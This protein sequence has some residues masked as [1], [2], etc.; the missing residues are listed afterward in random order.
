VPRP[1]TP[2]RPSQKRL[3]EEG[4]SSYWG[5]DSNE[6]AGD[7][8]ANGT[9]QNEEAAASSPVDGRELCE[10]VADKE[11][12]PLEQKRVRTQEETAILERM[13]F[14]DEDEELD[15][16][17]W[18]TDEALQT[19]VTD[20]GEHEGASAPEQQDGG[21]GDTTETGVGRECGREADGASKSDGLFGST[22]TTWPSTASEDGH[23][24]S[25]QGEEDGNA[26]VVQGV[27]G[28]VAGV[29]HPST[30]R[31]A[32]NRQKTHRPQ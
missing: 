21:R 11:K 18:E 31:M 23:P 8:I 26:A 10:A 7:T 29:Q 19:A 4:A 25:H 16:A 22:S 32:C 9:I 27:P 12:D 14:G 15:E 2:P 28:A 5:D 24:R 3:G 6:N 20:P 17:F 30:R 1:P 13:I